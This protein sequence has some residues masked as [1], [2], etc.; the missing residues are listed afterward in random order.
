MP[1]SQKKTKGYRIAPN[2]ASFHAMNEARAVYKIIK[3]LFYSV[4]R[5]NLQGRFKNKYIF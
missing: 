2:K 5:H 1:R 3:L 4:F